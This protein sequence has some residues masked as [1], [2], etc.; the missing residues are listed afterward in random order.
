MLSLK[1]SNFRCISKAEFEFPEGVTVLLGRNGAGKSTVIQSILL[2][3]F[4]KVPSTNDKQLSPKAFN[5]SYRIQLSNNSFDIVQ[6]LDSVQGQEFQATVDDIQY[7]GSRKEKRDRFLNWLGIHQDAVITEVISRLLIYPYSL[8]I[9]SMSDEKRASYLLSALGNIGQID[10]LWKKA[11]EEMRKTA[12]Q[13]ADLESR[14]S[15]L[16]DLE[17]LSEAE[18]EA[19]ISQLKASLESIPAPGQ[20]QTLEMLKADKIASKKSEQYALDKLQE[21][22]QKALDTLS[23]F[24]DTSSY[25]REVV[26]K[27]VS[28]LKNKLAVVN[29]KINESLSRSKPKVCPACDAKLLDKDGSLILFDDIEAA[30][31]LAQMRT[32]KTELADDLEKWN[33]ILGAFET[34]DKLE[35][36]T[37]EFNRQKES[38]EQRLKEL[39]IEIS[40]LDSQIELGD[41][42]RDDWITLTDLETEYDKIKENNKIARLRADYALQLKNLKNLLQIDNFLFKFGLRSLRAKLVKQG[43]GALQNIINDILKQIGADGEVRFVPVEDEEGRIVRV[44]A[45]QINKGVERDFDF[46]NES[47]KRILALASILGVKRFAKKEM[48][49]LNLTLFDDA[50][51]GL[52]G[53]RLEKVARYVGSLSG[54]VIV[55]VPEDQVNKSHETLLEYLN[56]VKVYNL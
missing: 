37:V 36:L 5:D 30:N 1:V 10:A 52:D 25:V 26:Q 32:E 55:A 23:P 9:L 22:Y 28:E 31:L 48:D 54:V 40:K 41:E 13:A 4:G 45:V 35:Q 29:S 15:D 53:S 39:D 14:L 20:I 33:K 49:K 12:S 6:S 47:E 7:L 34:K 43:M 11:G 19:K 51:F 16:G 2:A 50:F 3:L 21:S 8:S 56:P 27:T 38:K 18:I 17:V 46:V 42:H 24:L 44:E